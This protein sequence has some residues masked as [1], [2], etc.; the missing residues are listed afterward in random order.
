ME[1]CCAPSHPEDS[2]AHKAAVLVTQSSSVARDGSTRG[3]RRLEGGAF[4]MGTDDR[5][6]FPN[7]GEGPVRRLTDAV[8]PGFSQY[9][10][11]SGAY[12]HAAS[13]PRV[14]RVG[15]RGAVSGGAGVKNR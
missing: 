5:E 2:G 10:R 3:M 8:G 9:Q 4:L 13:G 15:V 11:D 14:V 1:S 7:D 6:G 12:G